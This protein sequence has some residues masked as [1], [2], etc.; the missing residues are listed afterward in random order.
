MPSPA[1]KARLANNA[2][3]AGRHQRNHVIIDV[4]TGDPCWSAWSRRQL[5]QWLDRRPVV[6]NATIYGEIGAHALLE[7]LVLR[8]GS[9][10]LAVCWAESSRATKLQPVPAQTAQISSSSTTSPGK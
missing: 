7:N 4:E 6:I 10:D 3:G 9:A 5:V 8:A 1:E 2:D